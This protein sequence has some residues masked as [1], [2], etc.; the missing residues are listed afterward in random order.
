[1]PADAQAW[2]ELDVRRALVHEL[3]HIRR[4]DWMSHLVARA[5]C[6]FYWFHPLAWVAWRQLC[7]EAER[8][9]DDAVLERAEGTEYAEQL[10]LLARKLS[11]LI[12][13]PALSMANRSDLSTRIS[14]ILDNSQ[15]RGRAGVL[16]AAVAITG[17]VAMVLSV[18]PL[19]VV[20]ASNTRNALVSSQE[21]AA[22]GSTRLNRALLE[23]AEDGDVNDMTKLLDAGANVNAK[24]NGDGTALIVAAREGHMPAV[25]FLLDRGADVDLAVPGDGNAL[26]MAAR[27]GHEDIVKLLL[28]RGA[29][30]DRVVPGDENALIQASGEGHLPVVKL[31]V[32]RGADVNARVWVSRSNDSSNGEWRTPL[33]MARKGGR[34]SVIEFLM[35][36]GA[37]E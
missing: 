15:A 26:I 3:E 28:D 22:A 34:K 2:S 29:N 18:A 20:A 30:I 27:E 32:S 10:V 31:L 37:R 23:A 4:A 17:T 25:K 19:R 13:P 12:A 6:S 8:A 24:F 7:V 9:C 11:K 36:A 35:S 21:P 1:M 16:A 33:S 14:A 5:I